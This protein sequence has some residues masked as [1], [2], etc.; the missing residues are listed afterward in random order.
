MEITAQIKFVRVSPRK[1]KVVSD[2]VRGKKVEDALNILE[3]TNKTASRILRKLLRSAVANAEKRGDIDV[4]TLY[5]RRLFVGSG[6]TLKRYRP[7]PMGRA[8][9]VKKRTSHIFI[10]LDER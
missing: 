1:V 9:P 10:A 2:M 4:D 8:T 3:F 6:P 5:I 7:A